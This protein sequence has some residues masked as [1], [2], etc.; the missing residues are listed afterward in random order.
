MKIGIMQILKFLTFAYNYKHEWGCIYG[1]NLL[2]PKFSLLCK[3]FKCLY[4]ISN[5]KK[6][7]IMWLSKL[8]FL[9][10]VYVLV[11][12]LAHN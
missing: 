9:W 11:S 5:C 3:K 1:N 4:V 12:V 7:E 6:Y 8:L 10:Y 2:S